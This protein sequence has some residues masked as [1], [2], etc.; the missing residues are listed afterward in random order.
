MTQLQSLEEAAGFLSDAAC[1]LRRH[2][3]NAGITRAIDHI[4]AAEKLLETEIKRLS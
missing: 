1:E 4:E 2:V 3:G